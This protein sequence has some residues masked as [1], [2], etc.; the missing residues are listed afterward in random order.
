MCVHIHI[1]E[2]TYVHMSIYGAKHS[3]VSWMHEMN[4]AQM[5]TFKFIEFSW[6][7]ML[8]SNSMLSVSYTST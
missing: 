7:L 2:Y 5:A 4:A 8:F 3:A 6:L 1:Y